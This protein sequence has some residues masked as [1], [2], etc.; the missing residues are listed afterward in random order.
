MDLDIRYQEEG[1]CS[2]RLQLGGKR[3]AIC[4][5]LQTLNKTNQNES[6]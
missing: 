3:S 6:F 2:L 5:G 1:G 4:G